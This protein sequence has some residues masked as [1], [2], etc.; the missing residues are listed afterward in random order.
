M[1]LVG[2]SPMS[3]FFNPTRESI[4]KNHRGGAGRKSRLSRH[5]DSEQRENGYLETQ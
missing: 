2:M 3:P 5:P 1:S 4:F